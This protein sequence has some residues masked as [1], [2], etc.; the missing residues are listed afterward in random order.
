[1]SKVFYVIHSPTDGDELLPSA[2]PGNYRPATQKELDEF[3]WARQKELFIADK[4]I[5]SLCCNPI[6]K[7]Y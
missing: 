1:V 3:Y 4:P 7:S 2:V 6:L 5:C